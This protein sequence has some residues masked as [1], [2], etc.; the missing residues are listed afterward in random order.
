MLT[1]HS[2]LQRI[3]DFFFLQNPLL[4]FLDGIIEIFLLFNVEYE[5]MIG[6]D[7]CKYVLVFI[8]NLTLFPSGGYLFKIKQYYTF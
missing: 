2:F 5:I 4:N 7:F 6:A 1:S 8:D 3:N